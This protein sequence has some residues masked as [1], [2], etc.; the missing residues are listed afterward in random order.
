[1]SKTQKYAFTWVCA[2]FAVSLLAA[3]KAQRQVWNRPADVT[4]IGRNAVLVSDVYLRVKRKIKEGKL[5]EAL[6]VIDLAQLH[7]LTL[8]REYDAA[9]AAGPPFRV[10]R[11]SVISA[12]QLQWLKDP[13]AFVDEQSAS[14]LERTCAR[15]ADCTQ[16]RVRGRKSLS[17]MM[18]PVP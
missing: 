6:E 8:M 5:S 12:L 1:M 7:Q 4:D 13:P 3:E 10:V 15:I 9:I 14:Y 17:E 18:S 16:G 11:D 2:S